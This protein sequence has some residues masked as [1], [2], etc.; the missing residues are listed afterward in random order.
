MDKHGAKGA[1]R[2]KKANRR[3][4]S[5]PAVSSSEHAAAGDASWLTESLRELTPRQDRFCQEYLIDLNGTQAAIRAGY[6]K[7]TASEIAYENLRKPEIQK[8]VAALMAER[9]KRTRI[10]KDRVLEGIAELAYFDIADAYDERGAVKPL[11]EMPPALRHA[12]AGI[13]SQ[14]LQIDGVVVGHVRKL[15]LV[16]RPRA[17]EMLGRHMKLFTDKLEVNDKTGLADRMSR[18]RKRG[19]S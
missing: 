3:G 2:A 10:T 12:I 16:D 13:E 11:H 9:A 1:K 4:K 5:S 17:Y 6:S 7:D 14:E 19:A 18:A 8:R 15:K